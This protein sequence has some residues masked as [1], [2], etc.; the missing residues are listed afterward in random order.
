MKNSKKIKDTFVTKPCTILTNKIPID[1]SDDRKFL[2]LFFGIIEDINEDGVF[3]I[4]NTT[5]C[6]SFFN[7]NSIIGIVEEQVIYEN[8][9]RYNQIKEEIK[10][11]PT[12]EQQVTLPTIPTNQQKYISIE[13]L[14]AMMQNSKNDQ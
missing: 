4:H 5:K 2:D 13:Q 1:L 3:L 14:N 6:K 12:V 7:W 10:I 9:P 8:D 11:A